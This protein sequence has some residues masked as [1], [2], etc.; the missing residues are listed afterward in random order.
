MGFSHASVRVLS[1]AAKFNPELTQHKILLNNLIREL[2][3]I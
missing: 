2:L 3:S 1:H